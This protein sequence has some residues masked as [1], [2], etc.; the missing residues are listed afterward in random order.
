MLTLT[1][2]THND[3]TVNDEISTHGAYL[4]IWSLQ[5]ALIR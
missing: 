4:N 3:I 2:I 1:K 5:G